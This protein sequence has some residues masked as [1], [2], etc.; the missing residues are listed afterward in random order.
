MIFPEHSQ[1]RA[2]EKGNDPGE[3]ELTPLRMGCWDAGD[4]SDERKRNSG[5]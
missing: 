4:V 1:L 3:R 5:L 2:K